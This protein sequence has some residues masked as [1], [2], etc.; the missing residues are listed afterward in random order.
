MQSPLDGLNPYAPPTAPDGY[1]IGKI[2]Y[3]LELAPRGRRLFGWVLDTIYYAVGFVPAV[4]LAP[5][6]DPGLALVVFGSVFCV[7]VIL[8][9][10][11]IATSG[12]S[13]AKKLL[14]MRIVRDDDSPAGFW[15][16]VVLR[17]WVFM[18]VGAIPKI[19]GMISLIDGLYIFGSRQR[20][21]HDMLADTKV[22]LVD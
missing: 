11:L 9:A 2:E 15:R 14:G 8:Q 13:V 20:C 18:L 4:W 7:L 10:F 16:G 5:D 12:Q 19:G 21:M 6:E 3:E 17:S 1:E 22:V